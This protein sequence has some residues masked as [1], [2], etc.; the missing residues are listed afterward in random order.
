A[1]AGV[2]VGTEAVWKKADERNLP[3]M[4]FVNKMERENADFG[5]ALE[6]LRSR[7][8][9]HVVPLV[10]PIGAQH[11][12]RGVVELVS[13]RAYLDG[14]PTDV[15]TDVLSQVDQ[16]REQLVESVCEQDD[17]LINKYLEG[18][19]VSEEE[20]RAALRAALASN[21]LVP[22]LCGSALRQKGIEPLLDALVALAP[23]ADRPTADVQAAQGKLAALVFKTISDPFIG[24]LSFVRVYG[25]VLSSDSHAWNAS[26]SKDERIGQL[27]FM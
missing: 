21:A 17:A 26:K 27:A 1:V 5:A 12:F 10:I 14:A 9:K 25:G 19:E 7:F 13:R 8:G 20:I 18:E 4:A 24:R 6:G 3:R 2:Q 15:P 22:V 11:D 16:Y 23:A